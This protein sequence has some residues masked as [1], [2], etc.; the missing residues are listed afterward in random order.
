M[1]S[2]LIMGRV[3]FVL[4]SEPNRVE[5]E[6]IIGSPQY[7]QA[8]TQLSPRR[9]ATEIEGEIEALRRGA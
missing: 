9:P 1:G 7:R 8:P 2:D 5:A 4:N 6:K 3:R